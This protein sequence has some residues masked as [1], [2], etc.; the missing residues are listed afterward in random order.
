MLYLFLKFPLGIVTFTIAVTLISVSFGLFAAPI[1]YSFVDMG[2]S[3]WNIDML[4]EAFVLTLI[5]IPMVFISLHLMN[6]AA[7]VSGR[8]VRVMLE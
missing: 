2:W 7:S 8:L 6:G 5:G 3:V 4:W 1:Y